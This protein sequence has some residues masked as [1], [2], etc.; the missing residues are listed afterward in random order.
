[1]G[2]EPM[3]SV[4]L[5]QHSTNWANKPTGNTLTYPKTMQ[6]CMVTFLCNSI[7]RK[8]SS[9]LSGLAQI[10]NHA[11]P[12]LELKACHT[13]HLL[14]D[15]LRQGSNE[16]ESLGSLLLWARK[17]NACIG[18]CVRSCVRARE[19]LFYNMTVLLLYYCDHSLNIWYISTQL[20]K[21]FVQL[22]FSMH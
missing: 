22:T 9:Q 11:Y 13:K 17:F 21:S 2:F 1:M 5:V 16:L 6:R 3:T 4:I 15:V 8:F 12:D 10:T 14:E 18:A 19:C 7:W 20:T